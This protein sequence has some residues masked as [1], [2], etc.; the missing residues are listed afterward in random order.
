VESHP[1]LSPHPP[2]AATRRLSRGSACRQRGAHPDWQ[3]KHIRVPSKAGNEGGAGGQRPLTSG[4]WPRHLSKSRRYTTP[5]GLSPPRRWQAVEVGGFEVSSPERAMWLS[6][7][8]K[9]A[10]GGTSERHHQRYPAQNTRDATHQPARPR[11]PPSA[12]FPGPPMMP[13]LGLSRGQEPPLQAPRYIP[14][15]LSLLLSGLAHLC[16]SF[17]PEGFPAVVSCRASRSPGTLAWGFFRV[18]LTG[19]ILI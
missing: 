15:P 3:Q 10:V 7:E 16:L 13:P 12:A 14:V 1:C 8:A 19:R 17:A 6:G 9:M 11:H 5:C 4:R 2:E 18:L